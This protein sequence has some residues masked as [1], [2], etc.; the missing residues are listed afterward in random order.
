MAD[1]TST[2]EQ[3]KLR[4]Y[5]PFA[6][7]FTENSN[8]SKTSNTLYNND[9]ADILSAKPRIAATVTPEQLIA[10]IDA[11]EITWNDLEVTNRP[12]KAKYL[13]GKYADE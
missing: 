6:H 13:N 8:S 11:N 12:K 2:S 7:L 9:I 5:I 3:D 1:M 4:I 10:Y